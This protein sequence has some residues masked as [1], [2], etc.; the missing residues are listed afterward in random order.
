MIVPTL[1]TLKNNRDMPKL[2]GQPAHQ[3]YNSGN[4]GLGSIARGVINIPR[5]IRNRIMPAGKVG[6]EL[7]IVDLSIGTS[8]LYVNHD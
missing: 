4:S 8:V 3:G 5:P 1:G 2:N 7:P 6:L